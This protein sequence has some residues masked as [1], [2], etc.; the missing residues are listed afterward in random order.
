MGFDMSEI[1]RILNCNSSFFLM[2][3][4]K[5]EATLLLQEIRTISQDIFN[6]LVEIDGSLAAIGED[7]STK[8]S[9]DREELIGKIKEIRQKIGLM[10]KEDEHEINEEE[11]LQ[12]LFNKLDS[13]IDQVINKCV[14]ILIN[15]S[16]VF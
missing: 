16:A 12:N 8:E 4:Q 7:V 14:I 9:F 1:K 10:E 2:E 13:L 3:G 5:G 6:V 11:I 15:I